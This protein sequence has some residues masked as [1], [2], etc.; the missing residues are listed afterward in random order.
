M[1]AASSLTARIPEAAAKLRLAASSGA[2][3]ASGYER[4]LCPGDARF[5]PSRNATCSGGGR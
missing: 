2:P 4:D 3:V 5:S 1:F